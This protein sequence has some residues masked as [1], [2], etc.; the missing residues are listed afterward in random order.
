MLTATTSSGFQPIA[1]CS[2]RN[3]EMVKSFGAKAVFDYSDHSVASEIKKS[4]SGRLRHALDCITDKES[5]ACC[6]GALGR[7]GGRYASLEVCKREWRTR[8]VVQADFVMSLEV[9]GKNVELG[10]EYSRDS[11]PAL[12]ALA[13][14]L[15]MIFQ[16]LLDHRKLRPH[17]VRIVGQGFTCILDGLKELQSGS[18]S[19]EKLVVL[20]E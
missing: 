10:G 3:F 18:V 15:T 12:H 17:P 6:Y 4:T 19:G 2:P 9:L 1:T 5:V 16:Q 8:E 7:P 13:C 20:V 14:D 11:N